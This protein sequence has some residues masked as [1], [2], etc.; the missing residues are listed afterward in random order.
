VVYRVAATESR[1]GQPAGELHAYRP[2]LEVTLCGRA[3]VGDVYI[4]VDE[5]WDERPTSVP[6]CPI[7]DG[8]AR[9]PAV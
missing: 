1:A 4:F 8:H 6:V 2:G 3:L 7:C 5:R 9:P